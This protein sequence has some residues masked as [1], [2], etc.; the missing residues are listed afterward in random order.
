[1]RKGEGLVINIFT[2]QAINHY[3][4]RLLSSTNQPLHYYKVEIK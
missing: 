3:V 2:Q 1:M 4:N